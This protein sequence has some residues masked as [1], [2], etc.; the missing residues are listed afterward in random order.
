MSEHGVPDSR[1]K[2]IKQIEDHIY[3]SGIHASRW[4][5]ECLCGKHTK[6]PVVGK[7]IRNGNTKSCGCLE[8]EIKCMSKNKKYNDYDLSGEYGIGYMEDGN[9]FWFDIEDYDLIKKYCWHSH[10]GYIET[11]DG[12]GATLMHRL[13][14]GLDKNDNRQV[15]HIKHNKFDN[16]KKYLRIC[17]QIDNCKNRKLNKNNTSG[18]KGV[19]WH[20]RDLVWQAQITVNKKK[21]HLGQFTNLSDAIKARVDAEKKYFGQFSYDNSMSFDVT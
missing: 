19:M 4:L 2:V 17:E 12:D 5:C 3:P 16:R 18:H 10:H 7:S 13:V 8:H 15:D 20:S 9:E 21:I 11:R 1:L 6:F 14:L